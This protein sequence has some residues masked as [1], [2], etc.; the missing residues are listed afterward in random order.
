MCSVQSTD[1][2]LWQK[3]THWHIMFYSHDIDINIQCVQPFYVIQKC[4]GPKHENIF[5]R[6]Q[7]RIE[8]NIWIEMKIFFTP[9][10]DQRYAFVRSMLLLSNGCRIKFHVC[11]CI[12]FD[13]SHC[14]FLSHMLFFCNKAIKRVFRFEKININLM[15]WS[16]FNLS[17]IKPRK[18]ISLNYVNIFAFFS[19]SNLILFEI[20]F[21]TNV[22]TIVTLLE[23]KQVCTSDF[24]HISMALKYSFTN[25]VWHSLCSVSLNICVV[26]VRTA[27]VNLL[28]DAYWIKLI[29]I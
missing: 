4:F 8:K 16:H 17:S 14:E 29:S 7:A 25:C 28:S 12:N 27:G 22:C 5:V 26:I 24:Y 9:K 11:K 13:I 20:Q 6:N 15:Q 19:R 18:F 23:I 10:N 21:S 3:L 1:D 2:L